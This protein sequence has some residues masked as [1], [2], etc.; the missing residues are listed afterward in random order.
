MRNSVQRPQWMIVLKWTSVLASVV[1]AG[2]SV[3]SGENPERA[4]EDYVRAVFDARADTY[5]ASALFR[6]G[7]RPALCMHPTAAKTNIGAI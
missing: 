7:V 5:E 6:L 4:P 2:M 1:F 3:A